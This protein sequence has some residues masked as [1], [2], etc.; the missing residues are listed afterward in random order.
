MGALGD[1]REAM[2][3]AVAQGEQVHRKCR[4][5]GQGI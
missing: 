1:G 5:E 3:E 4:A 2:A